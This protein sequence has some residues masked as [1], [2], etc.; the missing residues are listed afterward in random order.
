MAVR[1]FLYIS[2]DPKR[3]TEA[4]ITRIESVGDR[5][6]AV[7]FETPTDFEAFPGQFVLVRAT[8]DGADE[9]GYYTISSPEVA[10]T[11]EITVAVS[12]D[13]TLG[14]WLAER[15]VGDEITVEGPFGEVQ[16]AGEEDTI[17]IASG[18]GIGPAVGIGERAISGGRDVAI[19]YGGHQPPHARR[20]DTLESDG[21][22]VIIAEDL[23]SA[24]TD[25]DFSAG[26]IFVFGF[27]GFVKRVQTTLSEISVDIDDVEIE[28]FGPG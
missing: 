8:I 5:T 12:P 2:Y 1:R 18:P 19:V 28:N 7:A 23:G 25:V 26:A 14:P 4:T 27:E 11:F 17:V 15:S 10:E 21:A 22:A 13:G 20:L 16:Y 24:M 3:M 9:T 6:I